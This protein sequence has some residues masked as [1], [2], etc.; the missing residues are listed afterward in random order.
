MER[1]TEP[2]TRTSNNRIT[3]GSAEVTCIVG[4]AEGGNVFIGGDSAG[5]AGYSLKTRAD[6]KVFTKP[7]G[8]VFGFT[9]S[10]RMGQLLHHVFEPPAHDTGTDLEQYLVGPW[11]DALRQCLKDGGYASKDSEVE[12]GGTFLFGV[13]GRLFRVESDYQVAET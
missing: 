12:R 4:I 3:E 13:N 5:V 6:T 8:W 11:V 2:D 10:F 9:S 7:G 1:R